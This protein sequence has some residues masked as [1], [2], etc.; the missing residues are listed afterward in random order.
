MTKQFSLKQLFSIVD[1]RLS[2]D[3]GDVYQMLNHIVDD[4]LMTHHLPVA[5]KYLKAKGPVWFTQ[6]TALIDGVKAVAG[7]EF[8]DIMA[9]IDSQFPYRFIEV[10]QLK[11]EF[12]TSDYMPYMLDNSLLLNR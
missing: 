9:I 7:D 6:I 2:T 8:T 12:D 3:I 1:G 10:P 4:N 11:D 5:M